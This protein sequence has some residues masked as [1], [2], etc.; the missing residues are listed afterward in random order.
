MSVLENIWNVSV[1]MGIAMKLGLSSKKTG[2]KPMQYQTG[3]L[4]KRTALYRMS[5]TGASFILIPVVALIIGFGTLFAPMDARSSDGA[6]NGGGGGYVSDNSQ[7]LL[8][9]AS[10]MTARALREATPA[11]FKNLPKPWTREKLASIIERVRLSPLK[12]NQRDGLDL[13]FDYGTDAKG[14][15]IEALRPFFEV[16]GS[17]P[18]R[19]ENAKSL[20]NILLDLQIKLL[21]EVAHHMGL[22]EV[23]AD[24]FSID[25]FQALDTDVIYCTYSGAEKG[26]KTRYSKGV[27][28]QRTSGRYSSE[29]YRKYYLSAIV[30]PTPY[31]FAVINDL[32]FQDNPLSAYIAFGPYARGIDGELIGVATYQGFYEGKSFSQKHLIKITFDDVRS[33]ESVRFA[34]WTL[35]WQGIPGTPEHYKM[36]CE[37][38]F[39]VLEF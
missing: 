20:M 10:R 36:S 25:A 35:S 39:R 38:H 27:L 19:L 11:I 18:V 14:P 31:S 9:R 6:S 17:V 12:T 4:E 15:Y 29:S 33:R 7:L 24:K 21:H 1:G 28:L 23:A 5:T 22:D 32:L 37:T 30:A 26:D 2:S 13:M 3:R 8:S 16:Y 34:E